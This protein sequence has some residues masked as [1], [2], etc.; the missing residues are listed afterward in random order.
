MIRIGSPVVPGQREIL[1]FDE[2]TGQPVGVLIEKGCYRRFPAPAVWTQCP[3][4]APFFAQPHAVLG[5]ESDGEFSEPLIQGR[6]VA[7]AD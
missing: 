4:F 5:R 3:P 6:L 7:A 1:Y 2:G